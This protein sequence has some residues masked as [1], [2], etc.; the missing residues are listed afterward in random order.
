MRSLRQ[1]TR[2]LLAVA[3]ILYC[4]GLVVLALL[5][6]MGI[7]GFWWLDLANIFALYLF[8]PLLLLGPAAIIFPTRG[9]RS[10]TL[11][12]CVV[13]LGLFG[14]RMIPP[15][16]QAGSGPRFR[17][18]TFNLHSSLDA[19]QVADIVAAIYTQHADVVMLQELSIPAATALQ[20]QLA[21]DYPYQALVPSAKHTGMGIISRYPLDAQQQSAPLQMAVLRIGDR[22]V[23]LI[24]VSLTG[25][26]L[27]QR[28]LPV[29]RWV[30]RIRA[31]RTTK[32]SRDVAQLLN[33][34]DNV[35]G[36]LVVGGDFN[37]SDRE[38]EYTQLAARLRD[39]YR[40]TN[41]GF[42]HTFPSSLSMSGMSIALPLVRIDY[43]W[44]A[45]GAVPAATQIECGG[46]S[47]HCLVVA[48]I[49]VGGDQA[50]SRSA[51]G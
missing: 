6:T 45:G 11:I 26:E 34:I 4:I 14:S 10:A 38:P 20:Q 7:Q 43:V 3:T 5:W 39:S 19:P 50:V 42:G 48:D 13:F 24:N 49:H 32:R 17:V 35:Q 16:I 18:A 9:S 23:S 27:K 28:R 12:A 8:A 37:L 46:A 41:W 47:D 22:S 21:H 15:S 30:K 51:E 44:S 31:Y 36:P 25:P 2:R 29:V 40:E 1:V 33:T